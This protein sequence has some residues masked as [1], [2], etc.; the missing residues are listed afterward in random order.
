M[1]MNIT[2]DHWICEIHFMDDLTNWYLTN[3][4]SYIIMCYVWCMYMY[5]DTIYV[6]ACGIVRAMLHW[7]KLEWKIDGGVNAY[8]A[9]KLSGLNKIHGFCDSGGHVSS[10]RHGNEL[11]QIAWF[12]VGEIG[13]VGMSHGIT[14]HCLHVIFTHIIFNFGKISNLKIRTSRYK[15]NLL[16]N[17]QTANE[18]DDCKGHWSKLYSTSHELWIYLFC[19]GAWQLV[20]WQSKVMN[21]HL[22]IVA[23]WD[24]A[25]WRVNRSSSKGLCIRRIMTVVNYL[26]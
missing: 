23:L 6:C 11:I 22:A 1:N 13:C 4:Y 17:C 21:D 5:V 24:D 14:S 25:Q 26:K 10:S 2:L 12:C 7:C 16:N 9:N 15:A 19:H 3:W 8:R 18:P 20:W